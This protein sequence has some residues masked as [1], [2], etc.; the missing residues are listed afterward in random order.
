MSSAAALAFRGAGAFLRMLS[1][2]SL[3]FAL[4]S[5]CLNSQAY[6]IHQLLQDRS[7]DAIAYPCPVGRLA[8][9]FV[10][11]ADLVK[12]ILVQ[13]AHKT[14]EVAVLEMFGQNM[15][16]EFL[17]LWYCE[18]K[19]T[20]G[21]WVKWHLEN[22]KTV[23]LIA[24]SNNTFILR[25]FQHSTNSP[26]VEAQS[27]DTSSTDKSILVQLANL[28]TMLTTAITRRSA[29]STHKIARVR[30]PT[31]IGL[32]GEVQSGPGRTTKSRVARVGDDRPE[33][34]KKPW[35]T[36]SSP[37]VRRA[38]RESRPGQERWCL[39]MCSCTCTYTGESSR[40]PKWTA[41]AK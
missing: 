30:T 7:R 31:R 18:R 1:R 37:E 39:A 4:K 11:V 38:R 24:P 6:D 5:G 20:R 2:A 25:A 12:I 9:L 33:A 32:H 8:A 3:L 19:V 29:T 10:I 28:Y 15:L 40:L 23:A 36:D 27:R 35:V 21:W 16:C 14:G 17:V 22:D 26:S 13:L 34:V 41:F